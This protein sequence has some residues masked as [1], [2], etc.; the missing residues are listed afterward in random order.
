LTN[1]IT[2]AYSPKGAE[3]EKQNLLE[4]MEFRPG[5]M[6]EALAQKDTFTDYFCGALSFRK[7]THPC[8]Y[9]LVQGALH[10]AQF[11]AMY[12]KNIYQRARPSQLWPEL[13][14]PIVVPGHASFPSGHSTESNFIAS[15]LEQIAGPAGA[16][17]V[18]SA[19]GD[20]S[21]ARRLAQRIARNREV[22]GLHYPSDSE[23]GKL[24]AADLFTTISGSPAKYP[25]MTALFNGAK[26]EWAD[27]TV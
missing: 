27:F 21:P 17:V 8:T 25:L 3:D 16:N 10:V 14:P 19:K 9:Y 15:W 1:L 20:N 23:A 18:P 26:A 7:G 13:M 22:L 24:I 12:Y 4:A 11:A 6:D 5:V 2:T